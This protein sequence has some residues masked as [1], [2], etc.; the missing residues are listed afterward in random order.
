[1][2]GNGRGRRVAAVA[3]ATA[4]LGAA[5]S[6]DDAS[7]TASYD[8]ASPESYADEAQTLAGGSADGL[9]SAT[10]D[11]D[12]A[13]GRAAGAPAVSQVTGQA[14]SQATGPATNATAGRALARTARLEVRVEDV[15]QSAARIRALVARLGG[16]VA[17]AEVRGGEHPYGVLTLRIPATSLDAAVGEIGEL[18]DEV[19]LQQVGTEDLTDRLTDTTTRIA[20]LEALEFE[21]R[22]LMADIRERTSSAQELLIVFN[23]VNEVRLQ[24][25]QLQAQRA[26]IEDRVALATVTVDLQ[27]VPVGTIVEP[28]EP[29]STIAEA[30]AA[31]RSA[32]GEIGDA[33]IWLAIT[34]IPVGLALAIPVLLALWALRTLG[35]GVW[36]RGDVAG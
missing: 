4:L 13:V 16:F 34:V 14:T 28:T 11:L 32:F 22:A 25:E 29:P 17:E 1:M 10:G 26:G 23:Q 35:R 3:L 31:T 9:S 36:R 19:V 2:S 24:I 27:P 5:C 33:L 15:E 21:L 18:A 20:N 7:D 12:D 6:A 30:W 8:A